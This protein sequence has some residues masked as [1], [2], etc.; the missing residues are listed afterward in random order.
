MELSLVLLIP[1][2]AL[3]VVMM[4]LLT[5]LGSQMADYLDLH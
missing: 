3:K 2:A 4:D 5:N 1:R